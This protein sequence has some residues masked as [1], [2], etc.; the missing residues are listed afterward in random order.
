VAGG[1]LCQVTSSAPQLAPAPGIDVRLTEIEGSLNLLLQ[2]T[3][4]NAAEAG[5][6]FERSDF[7]MVLTLRLRPLDFEPD[8]VRPD[9]YNLEIENAT[10]PALDIR[11]AEERLDRLRAGASGSDLY[12]GDVSA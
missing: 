7:G 12:E 3:P 6:D 4:V 5:A 8:L 10:D 2:V 1:Y 9:L 11:G